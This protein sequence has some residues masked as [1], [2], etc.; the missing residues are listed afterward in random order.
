MFLSLNQILNLEK[1]VLSVKTNTFSLIQKTIHNSLT[2]L[3]LLF[4]ISC[5]NTTKG[6]KNATGGADSATMESN[7]DLQ[8]NLTK[9][10]TFQREDGTTNFYIRPRSNG[11][12]LERGQG[13]T[14]V[15]LLIDFRKELSIETPAGLI[16][17]HIL[18]HDNYWKIE[19]GEETKI[20]YLLR[21]ET[22]G[23]YILESGDNRELYRIKQ[24]DYGLEILTPQQE[25]IYKV[26]SENNKN[27][28]QNA[29]GKIILMTDADY[30]LLAMACYGFEILDRNQQSGLSYAIILSGK[31]NI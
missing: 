25:S 6:V 20:L 18:S 10:F 14:I 8:N 24:Q 7:F 3:C 29:S 1:R 13:G 17:G 11:V 23:N 28:L 21:Q 15:N 31:S 5:S 27:I 19:D 9:S 16:L 12:K 26:T 4:L 2:F 30:P 22:D